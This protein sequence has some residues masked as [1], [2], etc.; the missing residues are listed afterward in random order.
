MFFIPSTIKTEGLTPSSSIC[1]IS[2]VRLMIPKN[3]G[4]S[5]LFCVKKSDFVAKLDLTF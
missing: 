2:A 3:S 5:D 1:S 4:I